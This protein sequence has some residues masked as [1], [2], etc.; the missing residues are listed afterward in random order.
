MHGDES[1]TEVTHSPAQPAQ[2]ASGGSPL[3]SRQ[4]SKPMSLQPH[5]E[6]RTMCSGPPDVET[7]AADLA[8]ALGVAHNALYLL[9][10]GSGT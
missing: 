3:Y 10:R 8:E 9:A 1:S 7:G 5:A 6:E 2:P 4:Q